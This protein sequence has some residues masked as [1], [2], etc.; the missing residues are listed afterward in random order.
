MNIDYFLEKNCHL[1]ALILWLLSHIFIELFKF[2]SKAF[3]SV[4]VG[5]CFRKDL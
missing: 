3:D 4:E 5:K 2:F 1:F